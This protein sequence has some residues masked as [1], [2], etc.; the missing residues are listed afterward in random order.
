MARTKWTS[1]PT[2]KPAVR[3]SASA[4]ARRAKII[5]V[6]LVI[7]ALAGP[8]ALLLA[9]G[10]SGSKEPA[11]PAGPNLTYQAAAQSVAV[12]YLTG[13]ATTL[14]V[15]E[16]VDANFGRGQNG[17]APAA[18][19]ASDP[20]PAGY[21]DYTSG[22]QSWT[23]FT[24]RTVVAG[25][26]YLVSVPLLKTAEGPVLGATPGLFPS[27][28]A[29]GR[30]PAIETAGSD[31]VDVSSATKAQVEKWAAAYAAGNG[32]E[33]ALIAGDSD[34]SSRYEGLGGFTV[35][36]A[37]IVEGFTT[38]TLLTDYGSNDPV[39]LRVKLLLQ[40]S[41]AQGYSTS[42]EFDLLVFGNTTRTPPNVVA[43]G[44]PGSGPMLTPGIND[45][46]PSGASRS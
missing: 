42:S 44:S 11:A 27:A 46:S 36:K 10:A 45:L 8:L 13:R 37:D 20:Q 22:N 14:P 25:K 32:T 28:P 41:S 34:P 26:G 18:A 30:Y 16:G 33:L 6:L 7:A 4:L 5:M 29:K 31:R 39:L 2:A 40:S 43:W 1:I 23:V 38:D 21:R 24:F 9:L 15:A 19:G 3:S 12:D 17:P 35:V